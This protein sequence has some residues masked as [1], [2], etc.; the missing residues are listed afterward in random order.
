MTGN[1]ASYFEKISEIQ[2][3][4]LD[5]DT[6]MSSL[7]KIVAGAAPLHAV[8]K[9]IGKVLDNSKY[10]LGSDKNMGAI[11][12]AWDGMKKEW[13]LS[14]PEIIWGRWTSRLSK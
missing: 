7:G 2:K 3:G 1:V 5:A 8:G 9:D 10:D 14:Y 13:M 6:V 4:K 12:Q 11:A